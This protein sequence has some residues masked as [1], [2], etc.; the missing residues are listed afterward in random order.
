MTI[1]T[2]QNQNDTPIGGNTEYRANVQNGDVFSV[3]DVPAWDGTKFVPASNSALIYAYGG[4]LIGNDVTKSADGSVISGWGIS[5][6][7]TPVQTTPDTVSGGITVALAG[8]Y[9]INFSINCID[10][11]NNQE[12][13]FSLTN[14][15]ITTGTVAAMVGS[16]QVT[17]QTTSFSALLNGNAGS[18]LGVICAGGSQNYTVIAASFIVKRIG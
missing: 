7:S 11:T 2:V 12:Y 10:L 13:L 17:S 3:S 18:V 16:N 8:V 15:A 14:G 1:G 6:P 5:Q 4:L 9:E